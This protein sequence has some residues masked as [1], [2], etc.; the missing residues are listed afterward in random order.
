MRLWRVQSYILN[1]LKG[2]DDKKTKDVNENFVIVKMSADPY[3][4]FKKSMVEMIMENKMVKEK[5]L[6]LLLI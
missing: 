1:S 4:D 2:G 5:D 6:E 3:E